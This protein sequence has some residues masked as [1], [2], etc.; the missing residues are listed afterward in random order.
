MSTNIADPIPLSP[1]ARPN[2]DPRIQLHTHLEIPLEDRFRNRE[3][4]ARAAVTL[5]ASR[6]SGK[7][8]LMIALLG[9]L[10]R[11]GRW[12]GPVDGFV[13]DGVIGIVFFHGSEVVWAFEEM[14]ALAGGVLGPNGLTVDALRGE[15][16]RVEEGVSR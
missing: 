15:T 9:C 2:I 7:G 11:R 10:D 8:S 6:R 14:L 5:K 12:S 13:E 16:L 3:A 1:N 4:F